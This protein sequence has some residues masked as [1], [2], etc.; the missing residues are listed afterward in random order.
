M[1]NNFMKSLNK[2]FFLCL[3][4]MLL[5][6]APK[7]AMAITISPVLFDYTLDPGAS[8][9]DAIRV[10][11]DS[12][13]R[14][15]YYLS[16]Q[17]FVAVGEE[18]KQE[19]L[20]EEDISGLVSWM[21]LDQ[22]SLTLDAR[23]SGDFNWMIKLPDDAEPGGHYASVFFSTT[24]D[25]ENNTAVGVG[26]KTG[27]L[28][29]VNV[30]GDIKESA[31]VESFKV[32]SRHG[33][34]NRLPVDF[35]IRVKN[36]GNV[37]LKPSGNIAINN[38]FGNKVASIPVNPN[39]SRVLPNSIRKVY[40]TWGP[41]ETEGP[42]GFFQELAAEWKGFGIGKYKANAEIL[43]GNRGE[44]MNSTVSFWVFPWRLA[45]VALTLLLL[46]I[47]LFK[48]YNKLIVKSALGKVQK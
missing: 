18:G 43:Y 22:K 32:L 11:N 21:N 34:L 39:D 27:V 4:G 14:Q 41:K 16:V 12:D 17:N 28:F 1:I 2:L 26:A 25:T 36:Q 46:L 20:P 38:L 31:D 10:T 48:G 5:T 13:Q 30:N 47:V 42:K 37:H 8:T 35:E 29:L 9:Q 7:A 3:L 40:S 6:I 15:T 33:F 23:Q 24:P 44:K 19:Y 45:V